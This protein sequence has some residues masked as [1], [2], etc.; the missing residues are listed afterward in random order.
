[1]TKKSFNSPHEVQ[2]ANYQSVADRRLTEK[3]ASPDNTT[4]TKMITTGGG[5]GNN[6]N[7]PDVSH[8][9]STPARA[10]SNCTAAAYSTASTTRRR[11]DKGIS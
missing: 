5:D 9:E 6:S 10:H 4:R 1:M 7:R 3:R 2:T 8:K 11:L